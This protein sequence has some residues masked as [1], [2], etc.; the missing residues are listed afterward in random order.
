MLGTLKENLN[1]I[2]KRIASE[3][4]L[5]D[6]L[7]KPTILAVSK[8][9]SVEKIKALADMGIE[10]FGENYLQEALDKKQELKDLPIRWHF[11]GQLQ[12]KKIKDIVGEF[13]LIQTVARKVELEKI[14][15]VAAEKACTQNVLIQVNIAS[16]D[17]KQGVLTSDLA[18]LVEAAIKTPRVN[19]QGLMFFPPL[20]DNES[21]ALVW[22]EKCAQVFKNCQKHNP[23]NF[24]TL[25]MGTSQDFP[26]ALRK[27]ATLLRLGEVLL[28]PRD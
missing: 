27:G 16:E 18:E 20:T 25:S 11:I 8:R 6:S 23:E 10:D 9:Q 19:L 24:Q 22:F 13:Y 26:L 14:A 4:K 5:Q 21:E 2:Q 7:Q 15:Q 12:R 17:S 28:G 1:T 3:L